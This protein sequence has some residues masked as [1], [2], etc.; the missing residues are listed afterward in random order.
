MRSRRP[1][2]AG[3]A[4]GVMVLAA[5]AMR[6]DD[7]PRHIFRIT[8]GLR[9]AKPADW[10]GQVEVAGGAV[11]ELTGWRFEEKDAVDGT[12]GWTCRTRNFIAP[13]ERIPLQPGP[14]NPE[15]RPPAKQQTWPNGV[16]LTIR[17]AN[18]TVTL[19]LAQG[20]IKFGV[21]DV[22]LGEPRTVL[23][24]QVRIERLPAVTLLRPPAPGKVEGAVQD[25]YPAFWVRYKTGKQYL[26]WVA[27]HKAKDRVLLVERDGPD[28]AWSEPL[29]V[30]G[31]GDHFRVALAGTHKDTLWVT[32]GCQRDGKWNLFGKPYKDGKLGAEVA[33]TNTPGPNLWHRMMTDHKGRAWLVWQ[34]YHHGTPDIYAMCADGDGWHD[35]VQVTKPFAARNWD[36]TIAADYREDRVW[37]GWDAYENGNYGVRVCSLSGGPKPTKGDVLTPEPSPLFGAH[38]SLACDRAGRLW[39]AWDKS[40]PQW[41]KDTGYLFKDSDA[42]RLYQS[43]HIRVMCLAD[44]KWQEP[45]VALDS[46]LSPEMHEFIDLP[47]LQDDGQGRIWLAF[48]HRT[49]L[50]PR[51]DTWAARGVWHA[52]ATAYVG[53]RWLTPIALDHSAGRNDMRASS[54]RDPDGNVYFAYA[55]DNRTWQRIGLPGNHSIAVGRLHSAGKPGDMKLSDVREKYG[56]VKPVHP[57]EEKQVERI[58]KYK[59]EA[60]G[61][62]Y[63]IYRGDLHRHTDISSDGMGDGSLMDLHRYALDAAALDYILVADHNM[64]QDNEYSWWRTQKAND[65]YSVPDNFIS[66]YGYERSVPYPNGHRNIIWARRGHRTLPLP[67]V[68]IPAQMK[69]D[70]GKLYNYLKETDGI[71]T[72]HTSATGQGTDW[73]EKI[74]PDLEPIV[75]LFQGFHASF[76]ALGAPR[77]ADGKSDVVHTSYKPDGFVSKALAK[78]YRLGF[79][80]SSDHVSTHVSYACVL[81]EEFSRSG[82]SAAMK[83]RH[84]YAATDNIVLDMRMGQLG[85]MG[86]EVKTLKPRLD[87]IVLGTSPIER[88]DVVR[89]GTVVHT[90]TPKNSA[91]EARFGWEDP[92]PVKGETASSYYVR[93]LQKD[94]QMAWASPIWVH[95]AD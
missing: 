54:Q 67:Q 61:K 82:L 41:G 40:G 30:D 90:E 28:G 44:G 16:T 29:E 34:S 86:D 33:L 46:V 66:L 25:D 71:C 14:D 32:Y 77:V 39:A 56:R 13:G 55:S 92:S 26:A 23:D 37:V 1:V 20:E 95:V 48:R 58:R 5:L 36:P 87:V 75:E 11:G 35:P 43:R 91:A 52:F 27:Y 12:K 42:S 49:S 15:K 64:G 8:L 79:Q 31:P 80:A 45:A 57:D 62:T 59:I 85:I 78:G 63:R 38:V 89:N 93:V 50:M 60:N 19:K 74:N 47:Q 65:L 51:T 21:N 70:T 7:A 83:K 24:G 88:V 17:G 18:P 2:V 72:L 3:L 73:E 6:A 69:A 81:A 9:D 53:D 10:S 94:G 4:L 22:L 76:E 84:T 68:A